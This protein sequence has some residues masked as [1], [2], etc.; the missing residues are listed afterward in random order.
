[1]GRFCLNN[2]T[3]FEMFTLSGIDNLLEERK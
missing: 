3:H 2:L 1:L